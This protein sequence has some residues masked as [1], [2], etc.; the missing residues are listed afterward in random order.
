MKEPA[1][2][3]RE[4][5]AGR[6]GTV[7]RRAFWGAAA[8]CPLYA[9][10]ATHKIGVFRSD[11][12]PEPGEPL[13]W[14]TPASQVDGP[15]WAKGAIIEAAGTRHILCAVDWCGLS[16]ST[17]FLFRSTIAEA[18]GASVDRVLV[19][20]VHQHTAPYVDGDAYALLGRLPTPPRRMSEAFL[21]RA[22][23]RLS[24]AV[25]EA[26][27]HMRPFDQ[28]GSGQARVERV[29]SARRILMPDGQ[30]ITRFSTSGKDPAVAALPEGPIDPMIKTIAF[31][32]GGRTLVRL[33][34]YATHPQTFCCDGRVAGDLVSDAR[35]AVEK[36]EGVPQIYFTGC[37]G[38]VTVG[39]YNVGLSSRSELARRLEQG[40][41]SATAATRFQ[42]AGPIASRTVNI[43]LPPT[44]APLVKDADS[45]YQLAVARPS[46]GDELY[47][48]AIRLAFAN[49]KKPFVATSLALGG[50]RIL[51][52]PG[53]P[54]LEFQRY[55]QGLR[56][57]DFVAVAGYG[58][59]SPGY[60]CT[61]HA[62]TE[63]GY[64][65]SASNSGPGT[66]TAVKRAIQELLKD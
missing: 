18:A 33:Y 47:R 36:S 55:A 15:L 14:T 24:R 59:L 8:I 58:D 32:A 63:G 20:T 60:L 62:W 35:E 13:I 29:A 6:L 22:M 64:E 57:N 23:S 38:D 56:A 25:R 10:R 2:P 11:V 1:S 9:G 41:R 28:I 53:E 34:Y 50:V 54:M 26:A 21:G 7:T 40:M 43:A 30:L 17:H 51:H 5:H 45:L 44:A 16:N 31:A 19:Q 37:A 27:A 42:P 66:E 52:L 4:A 46:A 61:D 39:K 48:A 49:R 65:P 3:E 12:T